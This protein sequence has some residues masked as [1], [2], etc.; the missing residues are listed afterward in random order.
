MENQNV[1]SEQLIKDVTQTELP[2][3]YK[4]ELNSANIR[5]KVF[6]ILTGV[7]GALALTLVLSLVCT[8][9]ALYSWL[10]VILLPVFVILLSLSIISR[11]QNKIFKEEA[12]K[13]DFSNGNKPISINIQKSYKKLKTSYINVN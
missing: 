13:I 2:D 4:T 1:L 8:Q 9:S 12:A 11:N 7:Y 10:L 5:S 6:T 3:F